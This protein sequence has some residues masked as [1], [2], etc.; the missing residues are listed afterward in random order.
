MPDG[1][2]IVGASGHGREIFGIIQAINAVGERWE[3]VGFVDD[4]PSDANR[5]RVERLGAKL[6][7][8]TEV[9][10]GIGPDVRYVIGIGD[11]RVRAVVADKVDRY[12]VRAVSLIHPAATVGLDTVIGA[13]AVLFA[14]ARV[15]TN[16]QLGDHV[17]VN[18]NATVGHDSVLGRHVSVNPLAAISGDCRIDE[19]VLIGTN[20]AVLQGLHI[21]TGATVGAGACVVRD[22]PADTIVK[23]VPARSNVTTY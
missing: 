20:S 22:V 10:A 14:G 11:P 5:Q 21:G 3:V 9:L 12:A 23:G 4:A 6:L 7:G 17:H 8:P 18:Q 1:V 13:G 19:D 15:T 2:V 16:V